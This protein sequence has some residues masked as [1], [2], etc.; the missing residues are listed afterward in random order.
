MPSNSKAKAKRLF[1]YGIFLFQLVQP[2]VP[3]AAGIV[4]PLPPVA[5]HKL[6]TIEESRIRTNKNYPQIAYI[7]ASKVDKIRLTNEQIKE[8][9]NLALQL[10]SGSINMEE[11]DG[12]TDVVALIFINWYDSL[13]GGKAFQAHQDLFGWL[14][15]KY[16]SRRS[17]PMTFLEMK[18]P[19]S[20]PQRYDKI[21]K[22]I[23]P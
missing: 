17:R 13:F 21:G 14:T 9:N 10:N 7:P 12:V 22:T 8:F 15:G 2:L 5:I 4:M 18:K 6:S 1:V 11:G 19:A 23:V 16:D 20:M 3:C